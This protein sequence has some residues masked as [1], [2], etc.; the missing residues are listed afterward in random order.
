[1]A[2]WWI[3]IRQDPSI[4]KGFKNRRRDV[5]LFREMR[6]PIAEWGRRL[7]VFS[8]RQCENKRNLFPLFERQPGLQ[9]RGREGRGRWII[10]NTFGLQKYRE[11]TLRNLLRNVSFLSS[12]LFSL[13]MY[14]CFSSLHDTGNLAWRSVEDASF[15]SVIEIFYSLRPKED[16]V[17]REF[18]DFDGSKKKKKINKNIRF[19]IFFRRERD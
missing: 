7:V 5:S 1:M 8:V 11:K 13:Y 10:E 6:A 12:F 9:T 18:C 15:T 14:T 19:G 2:R 4:F 17:S 16:L 3:A